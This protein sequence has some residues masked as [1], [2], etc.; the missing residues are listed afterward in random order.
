MLVLVG[1]VWR[2]GSGAWSQ[3]VALLGRNKTPFLVADLIVKVILNLATIAR[4]CFFS[5]LLK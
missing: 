1:S 3:Y 4:F 2:I 5:W